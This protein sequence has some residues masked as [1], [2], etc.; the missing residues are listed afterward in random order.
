MLSACIL[1][2]FKRIY[3]LELLS[4]D[5]LTKSFACG[6]PRP[7][8]GPRPQDEG[9]PLLS[10][11]QILYQTIQRKLQCLRRAPR[12]KVK[13]KSQLFHTNPKSGRDR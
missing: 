2:F 12:R 1:V 11:L 5:K 8:Q 4:A 6:I 9:T 13:E 10:L 3:S 7:I